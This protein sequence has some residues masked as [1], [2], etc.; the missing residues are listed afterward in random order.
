MRILPIMVG[1]FCAQLWAQEAKVEPV[2][3]KTPGQEKVEK[4][5]THGGALKIEKK[6]TK[7]E[8]WPPPEVSGKKDSDPE[9][10]TDS[11]KDKKNKKEK[12]SH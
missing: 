8:G 6:P 11:A 9:S 10:K 4:I 3:E 1:L 12:S 7:I 2:P 5:Q